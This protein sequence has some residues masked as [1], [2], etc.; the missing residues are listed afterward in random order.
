MVD[1][2]D[3]GKARAAAQEAERARKATVYGSA[4]VEGRGTVRARGSVRRSVNAVRLE[5]AALI[6]GLPIAVGAAT[7]S[8]L[9]GLVVFLVLVVIFA[10]PLTRHLLMEGLHRLTGA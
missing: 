7:S 2:R 10:V 1:P 3:V 6:L 5:A 9:I 8:A 4:S